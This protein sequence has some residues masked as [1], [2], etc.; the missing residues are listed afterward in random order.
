MLF[1]LIPMHYSYGWRL[2]IFLLNCSLMEFYRVIPFDGLVFLN[3]NRYCWDDL[4]GSS[5]SIALCSVNAYP[6][7]SGLDFS[8]LA[9][10]RLFLLEVW[11]AIFWFHFLG[12]FHTVKFHNPGW[13]FFGDPFQDESNLWSF[14]ICR[15]S[16]EIDKGDTKKYFYSGLFPL[17][18]LFSL[19]LSLFYLSSLYQIR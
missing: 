14:W 13:S 1:R 16:Y 2:L 17:L 5:L 6:C 15:R 12:N 19:S 9:L 11:R 3:R 10:L 7:C 18:I 8:P 4:H